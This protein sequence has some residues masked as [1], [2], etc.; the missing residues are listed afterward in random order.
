MRFSL[1]V[2]CFS[3]QFLLFPHEHTVVLHCFRVSGRLSSS[4]EVFRLV[5]TMSGNDRSK[6][7]CQL[8]DDHVRVLLRQRL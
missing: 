3:L 2:V 4:S 6:V 1:G 7:G 5:G 8:L